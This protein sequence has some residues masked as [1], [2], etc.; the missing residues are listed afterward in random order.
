MLRFCKRYSS[1]FHK[2]PWWCLSRVLGGSAWGSQEAWHPAPAPG[3]MSG[4]SCAHGLAEGTRQSEP[5]EMTSG[6]LSLC[7]CTPLGTEKIQFHA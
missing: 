2:I 4:S 5:W 1:S 6:S 7:T 3:R